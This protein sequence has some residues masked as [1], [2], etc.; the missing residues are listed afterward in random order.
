MSLIKE[1][2]V[3]K[4]VD[5]DIDGKDITVETSG[6]ILDKV[7]V[8]SVLNGNIVVTNDNYLILL[9]SGV[10]KSIHPSYIIGIEF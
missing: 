5:K 10:I 7:R 6:T 3:L 9:N 8:S 2:V 4:F 1:K